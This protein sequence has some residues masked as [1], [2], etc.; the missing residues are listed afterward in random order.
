[1]VWLFGID[2]SAHIGALR[3]NGRTIAVL[4]TGFNNIYPQENMKL[5]EDIINNNGTV[6]SEYKPDTI[7]TPNNFRKRNRIISGLSM[8]VLVVEAAA[9]SGTGITINYARVHKKPIFG[10]PSGIDNKN[11]IGTN[12][13]LKRDGI[14]VTD[15]NDILEY[16]ML[17]KTKQIKIE[18]INKI[19]EIEIKEEYKDIYNLIKNNIININDISRISNIAIPELTYRL[20]MMEIDGLIESKPGNN[21]IITEKKIYE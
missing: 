20:I 5:F 13:L 6:I 3:A 10:I 16:F 9:K 1:M 7:K 17:T 2:T 8:G 21:Y 15:I 11:G 19:S 18:D 4:G 12:R 14:F